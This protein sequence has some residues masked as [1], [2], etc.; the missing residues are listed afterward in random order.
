M[1]MYI[2]FVLSFLTAAVF[3]YFSIRLKAKVVTIE[4]A[5]DTIS[6]PV[7][8]FD[9]SN[10]CFYVNHSGKS[11]LSAEG[12]ENY[13]NFVSKFEK[14]G[15]NFCE[16][17]V[18]NTGHQ[19][20]IGIDTLELE[21]GVDSYK[22]EI[23]W[24]TS[25]L[26]ALPIPLSVTDKDMNWTFINK[27]VEDMLGVKRK[28][29][30]GKHCSNWG[31]SICN[32]DDCG[33]IRLHNGLNETLFSQFGKDFQVTVNYLY[34][35][36]G[37]VL[38]YVEAVRDISDLISK[39]R[40]ADELA[41]WYKSILDAIPFPIS[42]TDTNMKWTFV[43]QA[44]EAALGKRREQII[45]KH[46]SE[47][48]ANICSTENC[49]VSQFKLGIQNT[50]FSQ[51][52]MD[53]KVQVASLKDTD[54]QLKGYV[55]IVQDVTEAN[56]L[57]KKVEDTAS[58]MILN[59]RST[60]ER[61][62]EDSRQI[63]EGTQSLAAGVEE[64]S[65][66]VQ[67]LNHNVGVISS[68]ISSNAESSKSAS[69]LSDKAKENALKGNVDMKGMLASMEGIKESSIDISKII[70][71]IED[72]AFQTNL[73]A[74][75]ASV[76]AAR[77]GDHGKGF[78]VVAEEVRNLA[79]RSSEAAKMTNDLITD[80]LGR[81]ENGT[82]TAESAAESLNTIVADFEQVSNLV[83]QIAFASKEQSELADELSNGIGQFASVVEE[84]SA[85]IQGL[86]TSSEELASY[87][88]TLNQVTV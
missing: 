21:R 51:G 4:L 60:S 75:N 1:L 66:Q 52:G 11:L 76:E 31:A 71:T 55:E 85:T 44:T 23:Y 83:E 80:S 15:I 49:G 18:G 26:D 9:E 87:A 19:S 6:V 64:Q 13:S 46:C 30:I 79:G 2:G 41:H 48:G 63:A 70:K 12:N 7:A 53:F 84:S 38:G 28:D 22:K 14:A 40:E 36:K 16:S 29:I 68:K 69:D 82:T 74:L 34:G 17:R 61:L 24:L 73:L 54:G 42:V 20:L 65:A 10:K 3:C 67:I 32:T 35:D 58:T 56:A 8:L 86:A 43:N 45:G 77:A 33:I 59:M 37:E 62:T 57:A 78:A 81:V 47:W 88:E 39:T 27:V 50:S 5:L 72:I 25:I